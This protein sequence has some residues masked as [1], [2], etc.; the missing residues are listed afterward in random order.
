MYVET[1]TH[2]SSLRHIQRN[3]G[4][5]A[6]VCPPL[7]WKHPFHWHA[8]V[9]K[10]DS[11]SLADVLHHEFNHARTRTHTH[12]NNAASARYFSSAIRTQGGVAGFHTRLAARCDGGPGTEPVLRRSTL[13]VYHFALRLAR[14]PLARH[15]RI[16]DIQ[17]R[18]APVQPKLRHGHLE[19]ARAH[20]HTRAGTL[21]STLI[22]QTGFRFLAAVTAACGGAILRIGAARC[23]WVPA[24]GAAASVHGALGEKT[25][26]LA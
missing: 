23:C 18:R 11:S 1:H 8:D 7:L 12:L 21:S 20:M 22:S 13:P 9:F 5:V 25:R 2:T 16:P 10:A 26:L 15:G 4:G 14:R 19:H 6:A 17:W 3:G 24:A